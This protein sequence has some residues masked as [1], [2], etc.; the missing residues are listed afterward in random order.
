MERRTFDLT[1]RVWAHPT[2]SG[3]HDELMCPACDSALNIHQPEEAIPHRLLGSC[4]CG[5]CGLWFSL[6]PAPDRGYMYMVRIPIIAE[7]R[8]ALSRQ[9]LI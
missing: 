7:M 4:T 3:R 2:Q 9:G 8:E 1:V 5:E 6:V